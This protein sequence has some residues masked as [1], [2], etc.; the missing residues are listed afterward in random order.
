MKSF[1][2]KAVVVGT[3]VIVSAQAFAMGFGGW[4]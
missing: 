1:V 4:W 2:L 3:S